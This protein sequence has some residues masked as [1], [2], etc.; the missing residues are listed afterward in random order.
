MDLFEEKNIAKTKKQ[1][2]MRA[3]KLMKTINILK[4]K[5]SHEHIS[6]ICI[7]AFTYVRL[8]KEIGYSG[9]DFFFQIR[10]SVWALFH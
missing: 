5:I 4:E 1:G 3:R 9:D 2:I 8:T 7:E 6:E 10:K